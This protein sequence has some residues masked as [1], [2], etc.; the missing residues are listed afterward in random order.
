[1]QRVDKVELTALH[2]ILN[3]DIPNLR[4]RASPDFPMLSTPDKL[5][6]SPHSSLDELS[7]PPLFASPSAEALERAPFKSSR[8]LVHP[9]MHVHFSPSTASSPITTRERG[10]KK[11]SLQ[12]HVP[13]VTQ[14]LTP[15]S[16]GT[17]RPHSDAVLD[18]PVQCQAAGANSSSSVLQ[19]YTV[20]GIAFQQDDR[21]GSPPA[22]SELPE[23]EK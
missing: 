10:E 3:E 4:R 19:E 13:E 23:P 21:V 6:S 12:M 9:D 8:A 14:H 7:P 2:R 18:T 1:M 15:P 11:R 16:A 5:L 20:G 17:P 22:L